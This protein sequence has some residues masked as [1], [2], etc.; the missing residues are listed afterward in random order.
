M[1]S[2]SVARAAV[3]IPSLSC[4][5]RRPKHPTRRYFFAI[6]NVCRMET[7]DRHH[8]GM[9]EMPFSMAKEVR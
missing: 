5:E 9:A 3:A 2:T 1:K 7:H 4:G 6:S 8:S